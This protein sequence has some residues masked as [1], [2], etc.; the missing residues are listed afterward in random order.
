MLVL[1]I[2]FETTGLDAS[3]DRIIEIGAVLW[4]SVREAPVEILSTLV[5]QDNLASELP[6]EIT[7]ITG[8]D[9]K[10]L[11]EH[12]EHAPGAFSRLASLGEKSDFFAAHNAD[13]DRGFYDAQ[14]SR[15][16]GLKKPER[17]WI[18]TTRDIPGI[19]NMPS[20]RLM[21]VAAELGF[22]NPFA[23]R[24]VFD[25][26]TMLKILQRF[27]LDDV[28]SLSREPEL[29][30]RAVVAKPWEDKGVGVA[31]AKKLGYRWDA[32]GKLWLKPVK[33]PNLQNELQRAE[34]NQLKVVLLEQAS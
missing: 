30:L 4:D 34:K 5:I 19:E 1:G 20:R 27:P 22:L 28:V 16:T 24:A 15:L 3:V 13:F 25:V 14:F 18:D 33:K 31:L 6:D 21:H 8:I 29:T 2:D 7:A 11:R 32:E 26:L 9:A 12:G 17:H 23:H 10:M